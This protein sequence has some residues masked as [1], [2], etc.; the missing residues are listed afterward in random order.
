MQKQMAELTKS[1]FKH[2]ENVNRNTELH[3][4]GI[5]TIGDLRASVADLKTRI[6][7]LEASDVC[8]MRG[9]EV[10]LDVTAKMLKLVFSCICFAFM[11]GFCAHLVFTGEVEKK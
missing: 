9:A 6:E 2:T 10:I 11:L 1:L 8:L 4:Q 5:K 7:A 3:A